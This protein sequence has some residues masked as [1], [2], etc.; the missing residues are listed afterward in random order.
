MRLII[1]AA[2]L[3]GSVIPA[4]AGYGDVITPTQALSNVNFCMTVEGHATI[5]PAWGGRQGMQMTVDDG[6]VKL[7]GYIPGPAAFPDLMSL[8]G[9]TVQLTGVVQ[10]D[11]GRPEIWMNSPDYVWLAGN[12]PTDRLI[13]CRN[14][15]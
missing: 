10:M 15:G 1:A 4:F 11:Y 13:H 2:C 7:I 8:D 9:Q 12:A 14:S 3:A 5:E 6:N